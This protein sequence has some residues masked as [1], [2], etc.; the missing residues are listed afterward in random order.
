MAVRSLSEGLPVMGGKLAAAS[1][2][3]AVMASGNMIGNSR[4]AVDVV[5]TSGDNRSIVMVSKIAGQRVASG[6]QICRDR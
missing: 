1:A 5:V 3:S 4:S 2:K 6:K